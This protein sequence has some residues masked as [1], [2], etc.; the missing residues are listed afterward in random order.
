MYRVNICCTAVTLDL[1]FRQIKI[2]MLLLLMVTCLIYT[3]NCVVYYVVPDDHYLDTDYG[4]NTLQHYLNNSEI[5]FTSHAQLVFL[6]GKHHLHTDL[7]IQD[8]QNLT[9]QGNAQTEVNNTII[10]CSGS[11]HVLINSSDYIAVKHLSVNECGVSQGKDSSAPLITLHSYN[12]SF[13]A[14]EDCEFVCQ[15]HQCGLVVANVV[16]R[17]FLTNITSSYV[18]ITHNLTRSNS[19]ALLKN[20]NH[21][22]HFSYK[23]RAIEILL[24]ENFHI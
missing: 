11:A 2:L 24:Y 6:P 3:T 9:L 22:G 15:Y 13:I 4:N 17:N 23:H 7:V 8:V 5:Y 1:H 19:Y 14:L 10:Y 16:G 18:L 12:C 20:Y 21:M